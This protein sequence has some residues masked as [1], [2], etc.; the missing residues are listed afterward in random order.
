MHFINCIWFDVSLFPFL[1][2]FCFNN[3]QSSTFVFCLSVS[4]VLT[5]LSGRRIWWGSSFY[6]LLMLHCRLLE[7]THGSGLWRLQMLSVF[8]VCIIFL[9]FNR[10]RSHQSTLLPFGI[11]M[12]LLRW[13]CLLGVCFEIDCIQRTIY[14]GEV[15]FTL[16]PGCVWQGTALSKRPIIYFFT[17][18]FLVLFGM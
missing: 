13:W 3:V 9:P 8:A 11:R 14:S 2:Q 12:F 6:C 4:K 1:F 15:S 7:R 18:I 10:L 5:C 17:V 16:T